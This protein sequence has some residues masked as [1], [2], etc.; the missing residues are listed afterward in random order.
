[1]R[2]KEELINSLV[3]RLA[4]NS[5][6][7]VRE[8]KNVIA[9]ELYEYS[10][11][12]IECTELSVG[13]GSVTTALMN[14]FE[15]GKLSV[16]MAEGTLMR[17]KEAVA[18][19]CAFCGKELNMIT[20]EDISNFLYRYKVIHEC[21]DTTMESK[22]LYFS[23]VFGYLYKHKK[24]ESNPMLMVEGIKCKSK[25]KLPLSEEEMERIRMACEKETKRS[26]VR[27][28]AIINFS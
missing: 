16:N 3:I 22:R 27:D 7:P 20:S 2:T 25:V 28:I 6:M 4:D 17:Y 15:V 10:V 1:M 5:N 24:I 11:E 21:Q 13:D 14:Y 8:L 18:Q 26:G 19:L 12:R 23:S 9:G